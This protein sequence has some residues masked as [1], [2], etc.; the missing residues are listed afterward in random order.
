L[1][2]SFTVRILVEQVASSRSDLAFSSELYFFKLFHDDVWTNRDPTKTLSN[3]GMRSNALIVAQQDT[4]RLTK[5]LAAFLPRDKAHGLFTAPLNW[6][7]LAAA[8]SLVDFKSYAQTLTSKQHSFQSAMNYLLALRLGIHFIQSQGA[9]EVVSSRKIS[10]VTDANLTI[11]LRELDRRISALS[12]AAHKQKKEKHEKETLAM[13][14][15][16]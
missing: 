12:K 11:Y 6:D 13:D 16:Q 5:I 8:I 3:K 15:K 7:R 4:S 14:L 9:L 10:L 1:L 2:Y